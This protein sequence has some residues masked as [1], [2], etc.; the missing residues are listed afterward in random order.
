MAEPDFTEEIISEEPVEK[1]TN[2]TND[3][4]KVC[5]SSGAAW[6]ADDTEPLFTVSLL[7][8]LKKP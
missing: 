3:R 5:D 7:S 8:P 2:G 4:A 6:K 1:D